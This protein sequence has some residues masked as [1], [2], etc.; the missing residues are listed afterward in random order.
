[1]LKVD[2]YFAVTM[3]VDTSNIDNTKRLVAYM[4]S[5]FHEP[6]GI[7]KVKLDND[8]LTLPLISNMYPF[9][10]TSNRKG[11]NATVFC[12]VYQKTSSRPLEQHLHGEQWDIA[13]GSTVTSPP[14]ATAKQLQFNALMEKAATIEEVDELGKLIALVS[15]AYKSCPRCV[16]DK[17]LLEKTAGG[18][19]IVQTLHHYDNFPERRWLMQRMLPPY[20]RKR[21]KT[22]GNELT[23]VLW[24]GIELYTLRYEPYIKLIGHNRVPH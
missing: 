14:E 3:E 7:A 19:N 13:H 11:A 10:H 4:Q 18:N 20:V 21:C 9:W 16:A 1:M 8:S 12:A 22:N 23:R 24:V 6:F 2:G 15:R 5:I 17:E